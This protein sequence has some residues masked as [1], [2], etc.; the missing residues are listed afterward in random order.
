MLACICSCISASFAVLCSAVLKFACM[1][2]SHQCGD[3]CCQRVLALLRIIK[4]RLQLKPAQASQLIHAKVPVDCGKARPGADNC[5]DS[6]Q[7][8][9]VNCFDG[10]ITGTPTGQLLRCMRCQTPGL[11]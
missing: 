1:G 10:K 3:G 9:E 7:L 4:Q 6:G 5:Q 8:F 2:E 11:A